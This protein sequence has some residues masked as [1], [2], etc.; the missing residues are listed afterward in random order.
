MRILPEFNYIL[1]LI[2]QINFESLFRN[3]L[4]EISE[5]RFTLCFKHCHNLFLS[6]LTPRRE[7][8]F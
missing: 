1:P 7:T 8:S 6:E 3:R 2:S 4:S 5:K